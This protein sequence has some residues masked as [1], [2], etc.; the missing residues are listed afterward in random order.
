ME[1]PFPLAEYARRL[2]ALRAAMEQAEIDVIY[3]SSPEA[4][5]WLT[6]DQAEWYQGQS[7]SA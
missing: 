1:V 2:R 6:G 5:C 7:S 3:L 4:I